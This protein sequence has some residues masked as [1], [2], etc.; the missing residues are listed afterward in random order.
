MPRQAPQRKNI[1]TLGEGAVLLRPCGGI[2]EYPLLRAIWRRSVEATHDFLDPLDADRIEQELI[3]SY[4]PA[5]HLTV[6][7]ADGTVLGFAGVA[8]GC[9]EM[10]FIDRDARGHGVGTALLREAISSQGVMRVDVNEQNPG[11]TGFY[12][13]HGFEQIGRSNQDGD[14]RPYPILHLALPE[15]SR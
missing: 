9:L 5:V 14:G 4:F 15:A 6:A 1:V 13:H 8:D 10:L 7:E 3:P 12:L 2:A 11:A